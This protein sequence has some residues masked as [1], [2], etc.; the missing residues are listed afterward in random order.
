MLFRSDASALTAKY[1]TNNPNRTKGYFFGKEKLE[2]LLQQSDSEGI[3]IYFG[4]TE[5]DFKLVLVGAKADQDDILTKILDSGSPC[6][7]KCGVDNALN[8]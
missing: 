7:D 4:E 5:T 6:P 3:R 1:R 8:S 2:T